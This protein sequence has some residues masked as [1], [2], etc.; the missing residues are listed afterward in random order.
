MSNGPLRRSRSNRMLGGVLGGLA[1]YLGFP[2]F[3]L[4][5]L[6]VAIAV[7]TAAVPAVIAYIA[8]WMLIP[9]S[10]V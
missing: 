3:I 10:Y 2:S 6:F 5:A 4:R 9:D 8:A 7:F 1:E